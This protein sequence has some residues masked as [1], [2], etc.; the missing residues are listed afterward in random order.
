MILLRSVVY[1]Y[2][3]R[4]IYLLSPS[5]DIVENTAFY[6]RSLVYFSRVSTLPPHSHICLSRKLLYPA[7]PFLFR[8]KRQHVKPKKQHHHAS[9]PQQHGAECGLLARR[10]QLL[11]GRR[12]RRGL[13]AATRFRQNPCVRHLHR[14]ALFCTHVLPRVVHRVFF[15]FYRVLNRTETP[16]PIEEEETQQIEQQYDGIYPS[17]DFY[18][19]RNG[20]TS[21]V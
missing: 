11:G 12:R 16:P 15:Y 7:H 10:H 9:S 5:S 8:K 4:E 13:P 17:V 6:N 18:V 14:A 19:F 3:A 21:A 1:R 2:L 20:Y